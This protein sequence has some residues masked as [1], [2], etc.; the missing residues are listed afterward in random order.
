MQP[1]GI[2]ALPEAWADAIDAG[3]A[4]DP[5]GAAT[6]P[7]GL[8]VAGTGSGIGGPSFAGAGYAPLGAAENGGAVG[9]LPAA[10]GLK[11]GG[12]APEAP[13]GGES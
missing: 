2:Q 8:A 1:T 5:S 3:P 10:E 11:D 9:N 7:A 4:P 13:E 12:A 6:T